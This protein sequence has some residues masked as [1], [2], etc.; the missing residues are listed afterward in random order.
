[1]ENLRFRPR[2]SSVDTALAMIE[3][4]SPSEREEFARRLA[5]KPELHVGYAMIP[6]GIIR[7]AITEREK[8]PR[9]ETIRN[10]ARIVC[11]RAESKPWVEI[12]RRLGLERRGAERL[13]QRYRWL[14]EAIQ[15]VSE[16]DVVI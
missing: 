9:W 2:P 5:D 14:I 13:Y 16:N 6:L 8:P 15:D 7:Q 11:M 3:V 1:M 10:L 12:D 4:L